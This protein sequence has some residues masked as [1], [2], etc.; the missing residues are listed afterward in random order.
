MFFKYYTGTRTPNK[1]TV[2]TKFFFQSVFLCSYSFLFQFG[3][4]IQV[5]FSTG[6]QGYLSQPAG[7]LTQ[8]CLDSNNARE[9]VNIFFILS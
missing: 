9:Q 8:Q 6:Q 3:D 4:P 1:N 7:F 5:L 2:M